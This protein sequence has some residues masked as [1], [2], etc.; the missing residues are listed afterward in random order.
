MK[1]P[2][3]VNSTEKESRSVVARGS[4]EGVGSMTADGSEFHSGVGDRVRRFDGADGCTAVSVPFSVFRMD[5]LLQTV[6]VYTSDDV[7]FVCMNYIS[8]NLL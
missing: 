1:F 3:S 2:E 8:M 5:F 4:R 6:G 7:R